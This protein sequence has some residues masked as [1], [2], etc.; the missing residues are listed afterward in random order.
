[1]TRPQVQ[2]IG[3]SLQPCRR[4]G[5]D[6]VPRSGVSDWGAHLGTV[7]FNRNLSTGFRRLFHRLAWKDVALLRRGFPTISLAVTDGQGSV[8]RSD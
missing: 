7:A 4:Q 3:M 5:K 8:V 1:M 2:M 6:R